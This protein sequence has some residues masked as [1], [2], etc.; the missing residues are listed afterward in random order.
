MACSGCL[1]S[2][3]LDYERG[4]PFACSIA[5]LFAE[6]AEERLANG[7]GR[8]SYGQA[9]EQN[10]EAVFEVYQELMKELEPH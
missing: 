3:A 9:N 6:L 2:Y 1:I 8:K 10:I 7:N 4:G 5:R